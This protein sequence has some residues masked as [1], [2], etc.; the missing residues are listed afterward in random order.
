MISITWWKIIHPFIAKLERITFKTCFEI[1]YVDNICSRKIFAK[2]IILIKN[3]IKIV[4]AKKEPIDQFP[5]YPPFYRWIRENIISLST[6]HTYRYQIFSG[7]NCLKVIERIHIDTYI[8]T[9]LSSNVFKRLGYSKALSCSK[10]N[11]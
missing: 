3:E 10:Y 1:P 7:S 2:T 9:H 8:Q 11:I 5:F 4:K 6:Y